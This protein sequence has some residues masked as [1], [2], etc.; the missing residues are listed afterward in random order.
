HLQSGMTNQGCIAGW[1]CIERSADRTQDRQHYGAIDSAR[2][3]AL[4]RKPVLTCGIVRLVCRIEREPC[5]EYEAAEAATRRNNG[6]LQAL[7]RCVRI[8]PRPA[9]PR[10]E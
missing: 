8:K 10:I 7:T 6:H 3:V 1:Y 5:G 2:K 4:Q 9:L